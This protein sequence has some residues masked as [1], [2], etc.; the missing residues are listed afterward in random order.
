MKVANRYNHSSSLVKGKGNPVRNA[1]ILSRANMWQVYHRAAGYHLL[2]AA[3]FYLGPQCLVG[4]DLANALDVARRSFACRVVFLDR[5]HHHT[6]A[7][8]P[9]PIGFV[10]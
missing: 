3:L 2:P 10:F 4:Q 6:V 5:Q 9:H 1:N 7:R 8:E